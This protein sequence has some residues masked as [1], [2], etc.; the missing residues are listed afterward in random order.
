[1]CFTNC[2][3]MKKSLKMNRFSGTKNAY[4]EAENEFVGLYAR[5]AQMFVFNRRFLAMA[6]FE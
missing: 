2:K 5:L 6:K 1:M 4:R 3:G